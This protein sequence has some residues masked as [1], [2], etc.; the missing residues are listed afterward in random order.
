MR[1]AFRETK[2]VNETFLL[3]ACV[4]T[5]KLSITVQIH[6]ILFPSSSS[7]CLVM[8]FIYKKKKM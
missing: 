6:L 7:F 3:W 4:D 8:L 5:E 2:I 1:V